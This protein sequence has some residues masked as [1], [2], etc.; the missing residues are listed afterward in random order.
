M[1]FLNA[2]IYFTLFFFTSPISTET[3]NQPGYTDGLGPSVDDSLEL[4]FLSVEILFSLSPGRSGNLV[5]FHFGFGGA[6]C[7]PI[8]LLM[9]KPQWV[10]RQ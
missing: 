7:L 4:V 2:V 1:T 10:G 3:V 8:T 6:R 9:G 5:A